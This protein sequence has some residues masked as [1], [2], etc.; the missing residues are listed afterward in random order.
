MYYF[1]HDYP[2]GGNDEFQLEIGVDLPSKYPIGECRRDNLASV[3][4]E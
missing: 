2:D 1:F 4:F 3:G